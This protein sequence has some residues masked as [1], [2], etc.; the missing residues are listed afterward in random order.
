MLKLVKVEAFLHSVLGTCINDVTQGKGNVKYFK[1]GSF[2]LLVVRLFFTVNLDIEP[3]SKPF[4]SPLTLERLS[5]NLLSPIDTWHWHLADF[6]FHN[7]RWLKKTL[8]KDLV[9]HYHSLRF[10]KRLKAL[11]WHHLL[12]FNRR[13]VIPL[14]AQCRDKRY[15]C[16]RSCSLLPQLNHFIHEWSLTSIICWLGISP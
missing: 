14:S 3:T 16:L 10:N 4:Q 15:A 9:N 6:Q 5:Q 2:N 13:E 11:Q 7:L 1:D 8:T 12:V